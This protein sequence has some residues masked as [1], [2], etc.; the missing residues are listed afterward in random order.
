MTSFIT[1]FD[2]LRPV[3][4]GWRKK[5]GRISAWKAKNYHKKE[6]QRGYYGRGNN[7]GK[8]YEQRRGKVRPV[9]ACPLF[10]SHRVFS[11]S[12]ARNPLRNKYLYNTQ[13]NIKKNN[14]KKWVIHVEI[15]SSTQEEEGVSFFILYTFFTLIHNSGTGSRKLKTSTRR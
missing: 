8:K 1:T 6:R 9:G 14:C 11:S 15:F 7:I 12:G 13:K 5:S 3:W 4:M 10:A 2:L